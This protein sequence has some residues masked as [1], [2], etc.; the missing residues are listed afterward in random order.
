[1]SNLSRAKQAYAFH[2]DLATD[3]LL[4][5][6]KFIEANKVYMRELWENERELAQKSG[7]T[8]FVRTAVFLVA[9]VVSAPLGPAAAF[10][11]ATTAAAGA[12]WLTDEL[13]G[14][15]TVEGAPSKE[16]FESR[17][18][19][20]SVSSRYADLEGA[21]DQM[22]NDVDAAEYDIDTAHYMQSLQLGM[23]FFGM[24]MIS[25]AGASPTTPTTDYSSVTYD[26]GS[27]GISV[28]V[29]IT[30]QGTFVAP[31]A[32]DL[33]DQDWLNDPS[34]SSSLIG[35]PVGPPPAGSGGMMD[36]VVVTP[37]PIDISD[38]YLDAQNVIESQFLGKQVLKES[39]N[40]FYGLGQGEGTHIAGSDFAANTYAEHMDSYNDFYEELLDIESPV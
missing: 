8:S 40:E 27:E 22:Q 37:D 10:A 31:G 11:I 16:D 5:N 30:D 35:P 28:P 20:S 25:A 32:S 17:Y 21:W 15:V 29:N 2:Q 4:I 23:K 14:D 38:A 13:M 19:I 36:P 34:S 1:M 6:N 33:V 39:V 26:V 24:K 12:S 3:E 7:W 9:A 18:N